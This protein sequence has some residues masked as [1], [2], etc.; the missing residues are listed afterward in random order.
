MI[1]FARL[2]VLVSGLATAAC[3]V[4]GDEWKVV[5]ADSH[6]GFIA[7]YDDIPFEARFGSF[8]ARITFSPDGLAESSFDVRIDVSSLHSNSVDRDEG[9]KEEEWFAVEAHSVARFQAGRFERVSGNRY[10]AIGELSLKGVTR[11]I[12]VPFTWE[13]RSSGGAVLTA[14]TVLRRG[15]FDI[16]TGEWSEDDIIGFDVTVTARLV[17]TRR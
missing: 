14:E 5:E 11:T 7:T 3:A 9:M 12:E 6:I 8:D 13:P 15:D 1:P 17:L 10:E 16:G 2:A 4:A